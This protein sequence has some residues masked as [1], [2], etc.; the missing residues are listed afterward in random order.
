MAK[1]RHGGTFNFN[2]YAMLIILAPLD[3]ENRCGLADSPRMG[4]NV[5][6]NTLLIRR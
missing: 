4:E 6:V 3:N 1:E 2:G 5:N